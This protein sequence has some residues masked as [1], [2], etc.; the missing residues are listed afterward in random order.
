MM[1]KKVLNEMC[2]RINGIR[3]FFEEH[4]SF[5]LYL[6]FINWF[7]QSLIDKGILDPKEMLPVN[8]EQVEKMEEHIR[9]THLLK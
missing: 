6:P 1:L 4:G 9:K 2:F 3:Y 7:K 8:Q 5:S